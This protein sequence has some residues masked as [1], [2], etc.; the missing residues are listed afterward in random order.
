LGFEPQNTIFNISQTNN[1]I[2]NTINITD[3]Y[4]LDNIYTAVVLAENIG[5]SDNNIS[6]GDQVGFAGMRY[7]SATTNDTFNNN[8][9]VISFLTIEEIKLLKT[10]YNFDEGDLQKTFKFPLNTS[11]ETNQRLTTTVG[12]ITYSWPEPGY[13]AF[14]FL[15]ME[16]QYPIIVAIYPLD[17]EYSVVEMDGVH[18]LQDDQVVE[19]KNIVELGNLEYEIQ[20]LSTA[21]KTTLGSNL[22]PNYSK[23]N[24][25]EWSEL[26]INYTFDTYVKRSGKVY[27]C[28]LTHTSDVSTEPGSGILAEPY[29]GIYTKYNYTT[30][31]PPAWVIST[32]YVVGDYV[33]YEKR[34]YGCD[35]A[36]IAD[37][38]TNRPDIITNPTTAPYPTYP[39]SIYWRETN[40]F[41]WNIFFKIK[42]KEL[43]YRRYYRNLPLIYG[44]RVGGTIRLKSFPLYQTIKINTGSLI[45]IESVDVNG[46]QKNGYLNSH[47]FS[48]SQNVDELLGFIP[49]FYA[50]GVGFFMYGGSVVSTVK[51]G[52][53][54]LPV[55]QR[56]Q[57][58]VGSIASVG[59]G[60]TAFKIRPIEL[61]N[62]EHIFMTTESF[63]NINSVGMMKNTGQVSDIFAKLTLSGDP[64]SM[65]FNSFISNPVKYI[66][67]LRELKAI[68]F[69]FKDKAGNLIDFYDQDHTFTLEIIE[70][71]N[72]LYYNDYNSKRGKYDNYVLDTKAELAPLPT[73]TPYSRTN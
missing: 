2:A 37:N 73:T 14:H 47:P 43:G 62:N 3:I 56:P 66:S 22:D 39:Y 33:E 46:G 27:R 50:S 42:H 57:I 68:E 61:R 11:Q 36:H 35:T 58:P 49:K 44:F 16:Y 18:A 31:D 17:T 67:P 41:N 5:S 9:F 6:Y 8:L 54:N 45:N 20:N 7:F 15:T 26:S 13:A 55:S 28:L 52:Q 1:P 30:Y 24:P 10:R 34:I 48:H 63:K 25:L 53:G 32:A 64:G 21:D 40:G 65:M 12:E 60:T 38:T 23:F 72:K 59:N 29:W 70:F 69:F 19:F 4:P 51:E 71:K